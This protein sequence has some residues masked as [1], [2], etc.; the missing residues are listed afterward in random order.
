VAAEKPAPLQAPGKQ[1][2]YNFDGDAPGQMPG[3]FHSAKTGGGTTEKWSIVAD[4]AAP[5]KPNV[6]AQTSTDQT[7]YRF[8]L[9]ISD[10]GSFRDLDLSVRFKAVSGSVDRAGGLV[11]RLRDPNNYYIVRANALE[12]NY[13]LYHVLSTVGAASSPAPISRSLRVDGT[14]YALKPPA[15]RLPVTTTV[16]RKLRRLTVHS[17]TPVKWVCGRKPIQSPISTT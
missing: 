3:K 5:S 11:F 16:P 6:I 4:P 8:P 15:R 10:E 17:R 14:N 13:R 9:L 7:D 2:V 1:L 12:D